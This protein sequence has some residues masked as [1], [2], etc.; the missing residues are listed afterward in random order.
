MKKNVRRGRKVLFE[1]LESRSMLSAWSPTSVAYPID[2][3]SAVVAPVPRPQ[4]ITSFSSNIVSTSEGTDTDGQ[5]TDSLEATAFVRGTSRIAGKLISANRTA[6]SNVQAVD[7][8]GQIPGGVDLTKSKATQAYAHSEFFAQGSGVGVFS[9]TVGAHTEDNHVWT[10]GSS[11]ETTEQTSDALATVYITVT[12][13]FT[14]SVQALAGHEQMD[15]TLSDS[16]GY[17]YGRTERATANIS[18]SVLT[19][20]MYSVNTTGSSKCMTVWT[21]SYGSTSDV[22]KA[23]SLATMNVRSTG[24]RGNSVFSA[25][26]NRSNV[27]GYADGERANRTEYDAH[28]NAFTNTRGAT[29]NGKFSTRAKYDTKDDSHSLR[30]PYHGTMRVS[31]ASS[32][33]YAPPADIQRARDEIWAD[34]SLLSDILFR[35]DF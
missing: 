11:N 8:E 32:A 7:S 21:D 26:A 2:D 9:L 13:N 15:F 5:F 18:I 1:A 25:V 14:V 20:G 10:S 29:S 35:C 27:S 6:E 12:G 4:S 3:C 30:L 34:E 17:D 23:F 33:S 22:D 16:E 24:T 19:S 31:S 28:S